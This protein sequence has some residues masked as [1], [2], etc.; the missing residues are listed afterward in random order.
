MKTRQ[1]LMA[2]C[3]RRCCEDRRVRPRPVTQHRPLPQCARRPR[4]R[5]GQWDRSGLTP[6]QPAPIG[7]LRSTFGPAQLPPLPVSPAPAE[8]R[9]KSKRHRS[10]TKWRPSRTRLRHR[11][12]RGA[13]RANGAATTPPD[14]RQAGRAHSTSTPRRT[15]SAALP[16]RSTLQGIPR[17]FNEPGLW[18][19]VQAEPDGFA[20]RCG[21]RSAVGQMRP[22]QA[23]DSSDCCAT[24]A[25]HREMEA[26]LHVIAV[27]RRDWRRWRPRPSPGIPGQGGGAA[28]VPLIWEPC[29]GGRGINSRGCREG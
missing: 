10:A 20:M 19:S 7:A 11:S 15:R 22:A 25:L 5:Q 4:P 16:P 23:T 26:A 9:K 28:P 27:P 12:S 14:V 24:P 8:P 17:R 2:V 13:H 6:P 1:P 21:R 18:V 3:A 29:W